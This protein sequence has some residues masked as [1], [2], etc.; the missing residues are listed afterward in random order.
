MRF[1]SSVRKYRPSGLYYI[2]RLADGECFILTAYYIK[3]DPE[4][5]GFQEQGN[6]HKESL[7]RA[8]G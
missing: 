1:A 6:H 3:G 5:G 4:M 7:L 2:N 8:T